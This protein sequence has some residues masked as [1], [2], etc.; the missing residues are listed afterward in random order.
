M[1]SQNKNGNQRGNNQGNTNQVSTPTEKPPIELY[2]IISS[3]RDTTY[4]DTS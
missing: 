1:F 3:K 4:I 2:R